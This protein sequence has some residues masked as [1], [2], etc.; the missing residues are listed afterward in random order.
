M[1]K[2]GDMGDQPIISVIVIFW[3][4]AQFLEEAIASVFAQTYLHW[5]LLLVDD[6]STDESVA[7]AK[8]YAHQYPE[9]VHYL[10]H[11][12]HQNRGMSASRKLGVRHSK[13]DYIA[14][15]DGD[16]VWLPHKLTQQLEL[17]D[18]H[19]EVSLVCAPLMQWYSW[20]GQLED[21]GRDRLYGGRHPYANTAVSGP[22]LLALFLE[23]DRF[24]PSGF[25][26]KRAVFQEGEVYEDHFRDSYSDAV[27]L[28]KIC[29]TSTVYISSQHGYLYR[30]HPNSYTYRAWLDLKKDDPETAIYFSWIADYFKQQ[31][32]SNPAL[33]KV[34]HYKLWCCAHPTLARWL[35]IKYIFD[36]LETLTLQVGRRVLPF[37]V[38]H[39][40]W[41]EWE[42]LRHR[43]PQLH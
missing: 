42:N 4:E 28:V 32:V 35:S 23:N 34:L 1:Q 7:I 14:Y 30:K 20:T 9:K 43:I 31:K 27:A 8:S 6:G 37:P 24:I 22:I 36:R 26:A 40:L 5:E 11:P 18:Q 41:L 33:W 15:L 16:D 13:G 39:R 29:L 21:Q 38:R 2:S 19:P 10:A 3:N 12:D 25:L 17:L